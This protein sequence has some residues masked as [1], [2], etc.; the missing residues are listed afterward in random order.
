LVAKGE[1][2][3]YPRLGAIGEWDLA[4]G[5]CILEEAGGYLRDLDNKP[6][7]YNTEFSFKESGFFAVSD[8][9]LASLC[10]G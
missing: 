4:A 6:L 10:C 8:S 2:D 3:L 5:Q 7:R 9:H 1:I